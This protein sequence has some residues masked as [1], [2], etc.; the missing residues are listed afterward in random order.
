MSP[1]T[2]DVMSMS[3]DYDI[4]SLWSWMVCPSDHGI[5]VS[6]T[7]EV[8]SMSIQSADYVCGHNLLC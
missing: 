8:M 3:L 5:K 1:F 6:V 7:M 4:M 2:M